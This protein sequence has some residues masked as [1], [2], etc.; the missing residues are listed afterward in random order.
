MLAGKMGRETTLRRALSSLPD[1][2]DVVLIDCPPSLGLLTVNA[3]VAADY[4]L[5]TTAA[6]Y[7]SMQGVEQA[8]EV[9]ELARDSLNPGL[10][11]LGVVVN[12]ANLRTTHS[13]EAIA[14]LRERFGDKVFETVIRQSIRYAE[15][16]ERGIPIVDY[17]PRS[18]ADYLAL[19]DELLDRLGR[20]R[21]RTKLGALRA[22]L[23]TV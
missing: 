8:L 6:Q 11:W 15:S 18:G 16:A 12:I 3:V 4:A 21:E 22:E 5:V 2:F 17:S 10:E 19:A 23:A 20:K 1:S 7:F 14:Q 9:I 13:R